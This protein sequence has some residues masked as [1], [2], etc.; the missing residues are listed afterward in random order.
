MTFMN[1][2]V[3]S[4]MQGL[5]LIPAVGGRV[6]R[7]RTE[8]LGADEA[9]ALAVYAKGSVPTRAAKGIDRHVFRLHVEVHVR[10]NPLDAIADPLIEQVQPAVLKAL[11]LL[12]DDV[13]L[14]GISFDGRDSD[15]TIGYAL[16]EYE[17]ITMVSASTLANVS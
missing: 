10:G 9:P 2:A 17:L 3:I 8:A 12:V 1:D 14:D 7:S 15:E 5:S 11:G 16:L 13:R 6:F 4:V